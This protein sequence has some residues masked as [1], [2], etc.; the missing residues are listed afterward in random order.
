MDGLPRLVNAPC[1]VGNGQCRN[2][3]RLVQWVGVRHMVGL[4]SARDRLETENGRG[5][6]RVAPH[7]SYPVNDYWTPSLM[8]AVRVVWGAPVLFI[9]DAYTE[10]RS[11]ATHRRKGSRVQDPGEW[12]YLGDDIGGE[13]MRMVGRALVSK[14]CFQ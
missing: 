8:S 3:L 6:P 2:I 1:E 12:S 7:R 4:S 10:G 13:T 5:S 11:P 9:G 14:S